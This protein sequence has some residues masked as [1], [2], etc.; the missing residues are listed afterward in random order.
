[1]TAAADVLILWLLPNEGLSVDQERCVGAQNA[2]TVGIGDRDIEHGPTM[3]RLN[4][5]D[6]EG[7]VSACRGDA[8]RNRDT[9]P[10][11]GKS[12]WRSATGLNREARVV[13]DT[14][15]EI[16]RFEDDD[17]LGR[18]GQQGWKAIRLTVGVTDENVESGSGGLHVGQKQ[19]RV[20]GVQHLETVA[21]PLEME[22]WI[23]G[24]VNPERG[25]PTN[26][27]VLILRLVKDTRRFSTKELWD[28]S[29][30]EQETK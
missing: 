29:E 12:H 5:S 1:M 9:V 15:G 2:V 25:W 30:N 23:A 28:R 26:T 18:N 24:Y 27:D 14:G 19:R 20:C 6:C 4:I 22:W 11:P 3:Y 21:V 10:I 13:A 7:R 8:V 16:V 17:G